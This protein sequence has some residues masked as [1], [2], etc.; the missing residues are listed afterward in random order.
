[1]QE[2]TSKQAVYIAHT[3][4]GCVG[5]AKHP[6]E[7]KILMHELSSLTANTYLMAI[8]HPFKYLSEVLL[9]MVQDTEIALG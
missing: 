5:R 2:S 8:K 6:G 3:G 7:M 4:C 1:M 9:I